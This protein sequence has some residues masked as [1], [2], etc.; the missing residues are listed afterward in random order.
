MRYVAVVAFLL[1]TFY[2]FCQQAPATD[3]LLR[4]Y[5]DTMPRPFHAS[6]PYYITKWKGEKP[7]NI[8]IIRL[9]D[10]NVAIVRVRNERELTLL[11]GGELLPVTSM[12]WKWSPAMENFPGAAAREVHSFLLSGPDLNALLASLESF[13]RAV[14]L[15][16]VNVASRTITVRTTA[17]FL[18][19]HLLPLKEISFIDIP[20]TARPEISIIGYNRSF[21]GINAVDYNLPGANGRNIVVGVKEQQ[22]E[23]AD[24]DLYQRVLSSPVADPDKTNH[25]TVIASIIGGAGNSFYDGRGIANE[26][27]FFPSS[28]DNLF[29]DDAALLQ[30][31]QVTVQNHSYGTVIQAYY[32]AEAFS[33]DALTWTHKNYL[34]VFSA[35]NQGTAQASEGLYANIPGFA[36]LTGNFKMA[37]NVITVGAIDNRNN[38]P[39]ESSAGPAFDGRLA[40]QLVALGP[41][42]TSDAAAVVSGTIAVMQQVYADSNAS[43][44]PPASLVK[45]VLFN[46]ADDVYREGIDYKTGYGQ[47][48]SYAA[49]RSIREKRYDG[50]SLS[51]SETWTKFISVPGNTAQ[52]KVTLAWTDT[53]ATINSFR[54]LV[55]DLDLELR[56]V[57][58]GTVFKPWVAGSAAHIDSLSAT[59][60]RGRDSLNTAE[61]VSISLPAPGIYEVR[62]MGTS[63]V[64]PGLAFHVA[65]QL[66]TLHHFE[67]TSPQHTSDV[68]REEDSGLFVRWKTAVADSNEAGNLYITY[69]RGSSWNLVENA[70]KIS[71]G[72]YRWPI[73]DTAST[74]QF[75]METL[76]GDFYSK[77]FVI[78]NV[79]RP[80]VD[81]VCSDSFGISWKKHVYAN[82]Y[83][84][85]A[86][87]D[88]PELEEIRSVADSFVVLRRRDFPYRV[89]AIQPVLNNNIP[90]SRSVA[91][92][93]TLQG[94]TCFYKTLYHNLLDENLLELV[95]ELSAPSF[96]DS[97]YFEQVSQT[98]ALIRTFGG[99]K[100]GSSTFTIRHKIIEVP[101]GT[102]FWRAR[103]RLKSGATVYTDSFPVL[104]SGK[105]FIIFYP[106]PV[107]RNNAL[108][109]TLQQ[110]LP[111]DSR[112]QL[113]DISGRLLREYTELTGSID[114]RGLA[115]GMI[116]YK[117]SRRN[118]QPVEKGKLIIQ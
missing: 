68:N 81:F 55:N 104:T 79:T 101:P 16:S 99:S 74:A 44:I 32:G 75:R 8:T 65:W 61:Q 71:R 89:Y 90:A 86:L 87:G 92:D 2:S 3:R 70:V 1:I 111:V 24:L 38:I 53:M 73:K 106:N 56:E 102:T 19:Q 63:V 97:V 57:N 46:S 69:N 18:N 115:P 5:G 31:N 112:L 26:C 105:K 14:S 93:I 84:I 82:G 83:K 17:D 27:R 66:D 60:T 7:R 114:T 116:I 25:A 109:Y 22:M 54:T 42:G 11:R 91:F 52:L 28:F 100:A 43:V 10:K 30:A 59:A 107:T 37:K 15:I 21:H 58:S 88:K 72:L 118:G 113:F 35:G 34:A 47:L 33:Y 29:A 39:T 48:N 94:T 50:G 95:L 23:P 40:P 62:V 20:Q 96:V 77:E 108:T 110:G 64:N 78:S 13:K 41:N 12:K 51:Q 49:I 117:L 6:Q 45:A 4:Q 85:F 9:L 98:G 36:N 103:I 67:F 76:F 80:V